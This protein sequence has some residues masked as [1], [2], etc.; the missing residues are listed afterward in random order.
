VALAVQQLFGNQSLSDPKREDIVRSLASLLV[1]E[2]R[3]AEAAAQFASLY[4]VTRE[5]ATGKS[6]KYLFEQANLLSDFSDASAKK[7]LEAYEA[8]PPDRQQAFKYTLVQTL[9][10]VNKL[11]LALKEIDTLE[12]ETKEKDLRWTILRARAARLGGR[13]DDAKRLITEAIDSITKAGGDQ[14]ILLAETLVEKGRI[15]LELDDL[16]GASAAATS[17]ADK[18]EKVYSSY[19]VLGRVRLKEKKPAMAIDLAKKAITQNQYYTDA[20]ML[21]GDGYMANGDPKAAAE[22][23]KKAIA[24]YPGLL[25][26][27]KSLLKSY[28]ALDLSDEA[29]KEEEQIAV[30]EKAQ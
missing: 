1:V 21:L 10:K 16:Q 4:A 17:A 24:V 19:V 15:L 6:D 12:G 5:T 7:L 9:L 22:Q 29:R 30:M 27:H 11:D 13:H 18:Y 20:Y 14:S 2:G 28:K 25:N 23:Y 8:L 26:A 3:Y